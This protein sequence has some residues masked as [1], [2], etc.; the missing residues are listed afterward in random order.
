MRKQYKLSKIKNKKKLQKK[1][2][3][4][5]SLKRLRSLLSYFQIWR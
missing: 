4:G 1:N 5:G 3:N 2:F